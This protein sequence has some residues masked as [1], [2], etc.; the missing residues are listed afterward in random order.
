MSR[1]ARTS[2]REELPETVSGLPE[3]SNEDVKPDTNPFTNPD[4][5][6]L[7]YAW[8]GFLLRLLLIGGGVFTVVQYVQTRD[9]TRIER[10]L[11]LVELWERAEY[12]SAQKAIED[13][14]QGLNAQ[15]AGLL[16]TNP[17]DAEKAV[18]NER[19]GIAAM[20]PEGGSM[21]LDEFEEHVGRIVYFLNR[22]A[23]CV[24]GN[25][26]KRDVADAYFR[27]YGQSFWAYFAGYV[28]ARRRDGAPSYAV[29]IEEWLK[30]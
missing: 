18:Y 22:V 1:E 28:E 13:R 2:P 19:I 11:E 6:M 16:G 27:D 15:Y 29:T 25:L 17:S 4:W 8:S 30:E 21:P 5:R 26:C 10:A 23:F 20:T 7:G 24:R 3:K 14:L 12:Q 9:E